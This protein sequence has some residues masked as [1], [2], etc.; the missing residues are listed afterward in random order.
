MVKF[1]RQNLSQK[2]GN[3]LRLLKLLL[4]LLLLLSRISPVQLYVTPETAAHQ[5]P[6]CLGF[7]R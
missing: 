5:A 3:M 1:I 4:L 2:R 7:F 6:P